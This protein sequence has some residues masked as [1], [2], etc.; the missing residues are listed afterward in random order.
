L[1][2]R[3]RKTLASQLDRLDSVLDGLAENLNQAVADAVQGAVHKALVELMTNPELI[4]LVGG[5][6]G[7]AAP[8][9]A[10][11]PPEALPVQPDD[12]PTLGQ[13]LG[14]ARDWAGAQ[15]RGAGAACGRGVRAGLE[16][17]SGLKPRLLAL[18]RLRKPLLVALAVG[19]AAG[20]AAFAAGPWVAGLLTGLAGSAAAL[21]VQT[22]L[23][24]QKAF[25]GFAI[26][27]ES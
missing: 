10:L 18:W 8:T 11:T 2:N 7:R 12:R 25:G 27:A 20:V 23:W 5:A 1:N 9:P 4:A 26:P 16:N 14:Q 15:V 3:P 19:T 22:R 24:L 17:L 13:R 21:A 6:A